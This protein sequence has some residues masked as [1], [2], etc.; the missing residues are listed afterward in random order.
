MMF[1][2]QLAQF[3]LLLRAHTKRPRSAHDFFK[4]PAIFVRYWLIWLSIC[5]YTKFKCC[6]THRGYRP[7]T[8]A[9]LFLA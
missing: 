6:E 5:E 4:R 2:V 8:D 9:A 7:S 1:Y 3:W